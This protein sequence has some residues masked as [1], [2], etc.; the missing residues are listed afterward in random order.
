MNDSV[1]EQIDRNRAPL[2]A[3]CEKYGVARLDIFGSGTTTEWRPGAS[4]LDFVVVFR[5]Q[6]GKSLADR[7]LG[8]AEDLEGLF[9]RP[10][11]LLTERSIRNPY[12]RQ[13]V[14]ATRTPV[15]AA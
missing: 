2:A 8:L 3:L 10:V 4:D 11:D 14:E 12:F 9:G 6:L 1:K 15:Y 5:E 13:A 7:Y